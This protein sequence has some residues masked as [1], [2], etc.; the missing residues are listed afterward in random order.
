MGIRVVSLCVLP[1]VPGMRASPL[2]I[3][4]ALP[5]LPAWPSLSSR[6]DLLNQMWGISVLRSSLSYLIMAPMHKRC[7][8]L[9]TAVLCYFLLLPVSY[10]I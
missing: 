8:M 9:S 10:C 3:T 7:D 6:L 4:C 1:M 5:E 2:P